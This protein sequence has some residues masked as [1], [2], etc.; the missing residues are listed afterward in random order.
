MRCLGI[1]KWQCHFGSSPRHP[2]GLIRRE[3]EHPADRAHISSCM[4]AADPEEQLPL[5]YQV[6]LQRVLNWNRWW[7]IVARSLLRAFQR[8]YWGLLGNHLKTVTGVVNPHLAQ[9][10]LEYGRGSWPIASAVER[11]RPKV[12]A[13]RLLLTQYI[14][15][16]KAN[17][18]P[19]DGRRRK[20]KGP[21]S[22]LA[23]PRLERVSD[24]E[25]E[26][27]E[28]SAGEKEGSYALRL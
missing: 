13:G 21:P 27:S 6:P 26:H 4:Q 10:R 14:M 12:E 2:P 18:H 20:E 16:D 28:D 9:V 19:T 1:P 5:I 3:R 8:R 15:A 22:N 7:H 11:D 23:L 24:T 17:V 25:R